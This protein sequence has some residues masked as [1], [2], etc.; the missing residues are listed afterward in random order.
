MDRCFEVSSKTVLL[1][2]EGYEVILCALRNSRKKAKQLA[3]LEMLYL[4]WD[5][6]IGFIKNQP[7]GEMSGVFTLAIPKIH[8]KEIAASLCKAGYCDRFYR[9]ELADTVQNSYSWKGQRVALTN[10]FT[11]DKNE[12]RNTSSHNRIFKIADKENNI[13]TIK[14]YRGD[15]GDISRRALPVEDAR[16]MLNLGCPEK[17]HTMLEPFAGAGGIVFEAKK[18]FPH[19]HITTVDIDPAL[20][21]GL[22]DF[23]DEHITGDIAAIDFGG[24]CFDIIVT[25]APFSDTATAAVIAGLHNIFKR[26]NK[27]ARVVI[28]CGLSQHEAIKSALRECGGHV[29]LEKQI[30][31]KGTPVCI[32]AASPQ[33]P[34]PDEAD[35]LKCVAEIY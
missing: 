3:I 4:F 15:G 34:E 25:E 7:I 14:G 24:H 31:R 8:F 26:L 18:N 12:Y 22:G 28:M 5:K 6:G 16:C 32:L 9:L 29:Y 10:L 17:A 2:F 21:P 19:L 27:G 13:I 30:D 33:E 23:G 11:Q 20:A 1:L 35:L